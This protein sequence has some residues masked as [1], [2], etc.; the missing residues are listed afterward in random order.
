MNSENADIL[1]A[2]WDSVRHDALPR[3]SRCLYRSFQLPAGRR[4]A[5]YL[6]SPTSSNWGCSRSGGRNHAIHPVGTRCPDDLDRQTVR[7]ILTSSSGTRHL[8]PCRQLSFQT[9]YCA[10][11]TIPNTSS[12]SRPQADH[13]HEAKTRPC[14]D[15][16]NGRISDVIGETSTVHR[17]D[18]RYFHGHALPCI[19]C[20][21]GDGPW[22][23]V[24]SRYGNMER[25]LSDTVR[26]L[27]WGSLQRCDSARPRP[28]TTCGSV[29][30]LRDRFGSNSPEFH[31]RN[32]DYKVTIGRNSFYS[33]HGLRAGPRHPV[34]GAA[35]HGRHGQARYGPG[36]SR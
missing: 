33:L 20:S 6:E 30:L 10:V 25:P 24:P 31:T 18:I 13:V 35:S 17:W 12:A 11:G 36:S 26:R 19:G 3:I 23:T 27:C 14:N 15:W 32:I 8:G 9:A 28:S 22:T 29:H 1:A 16:G 2:V 4:H 7:P 5:V 34:F 21:A